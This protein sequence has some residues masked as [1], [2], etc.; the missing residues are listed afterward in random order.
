MATVTEEL[1][2][3]I[4]VKLSE[5]KKGRMKT[6]K[7]GW[8][9]VLAELALISCAHPLRTYPATDLFFK[10]EGFPVPREFRLGTARLADVNAWSVSLQ[11][12]QQPL[13]SMRLDIDFDGIPELFV[14]QPAFTGNGG[15]AHLVFH[16]GKRGFQY[17]GRLFFRGIRPTKPGV[18]GKPRVLISSWMGEGKLNVAVH[19]LEG[20]GFHEIVN[21]VLPGSDGAVWADPEGGRLLK[22]LFDSEVPSE[23]VLR[24]AFGEKLYLQ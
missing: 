2:R 11:G 13:Q 14:S 9:L 22:R 5:K 3:S 8:W 16:E 6:S 12:S 21:R 24:A 18:D 20:D 4:P 23:D 1:P 17:L 19:V 10:G 7:F 15:N